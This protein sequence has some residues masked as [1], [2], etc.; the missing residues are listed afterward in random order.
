MIARMRKSLSTGLGVGVF[1]SSFVSSTA[2]VRGDNGS[3]VIGLK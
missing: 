1:D 3:A 2:G